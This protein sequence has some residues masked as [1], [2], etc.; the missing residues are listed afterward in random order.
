M[1]GIQGINGLPPTPDR[2]GE[3]RDRNRSEKAENKPADGV[4][5]SSEAQGAANA[6][7]AVQLAAS[8]SDVRPDRVAAARAALDA[9]E[10][11]LDDRLSEVAKK[12]LRIL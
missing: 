12:L 10:Y 3:T 8:E 4:S 5:L 2:P 6:A 9:G 11:K 1:G 7:E